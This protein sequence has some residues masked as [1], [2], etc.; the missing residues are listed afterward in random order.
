MKV[1]TTY[2]ATLHLEK[3]QFTEKA[4]T[5]H[6]AADTTGPLPCADSSLSIKFS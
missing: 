3:H 5:D 6:R 2:F 1:E 4:A